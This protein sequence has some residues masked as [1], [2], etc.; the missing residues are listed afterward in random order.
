MRFIRGLSF[1]NVIDRYHRVRQGKLVDGEA[2]TLRQL[3]TR[4]V[5]VCEAMAYAHSRG[6]LHRDLKP[7]NIMLGLYGETLVVDWGL[8]KTDEQRTDSEAVSSSPESKVR[9]SGG[10]PTQLGSALGT[11]G[12]MSPEQAR[13]A[14][15]RLTQATDIYSLGATMYCLLTGRA[16]IQGKE[17]GQVLE[18]TCLG[19]FPKPRALVADLPRP[20]QSICL[21]S[22]ALHPNDRYETSLELLSVV[23]KKQSKQASKLAGSRHVRKNTTNW[24]FK[25]WISF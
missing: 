1:G 3:L 9:V 11:P 19:E 21:C 18:Q 2:M 4:F 23:N 12:Y 16:P 8:A 17:M 13:G 14:V 24:R 25:P 10:T 5:D 15:D 7:E 6:V 22:L 20:L